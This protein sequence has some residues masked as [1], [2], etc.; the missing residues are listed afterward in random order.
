MKGSSSSSSSSSNGETN[1][2]SAKVACQN[3]SSSMLTPSSTNSS[4]LSSSTSPS[5]LHSSPSTCSAN[6]L[7]STSS[8]IAQ[9]NKLNSIEK[10][11]KTNHTLAKPSHSPHSYSNTTLT[12]SASP[13][14]YESLPSS[15]GIQGS[16]PASNSTTTPSNGAYLYSQY[17][18]GSN[19]FYPSETSASFVPQ[20]LSPSN[21][22]Y[23]TSSLTKPETSFANPSILNPID[24]NINYNNSYS[25]NNNSNILG[26][27][28]T[29]NNNNASST[30][31]NSANLN[32]L[33]PTGSHTKD[34]F[35]YNNSAYSQNYNLN[36]NNNSEKMNVDNATNYG[37][38]T[39]GSIGQEFTQ[40]HL[41]HTYSNQRMDVSASTFA[42]SV[43]EPSALISN[44]SSAYSHPSPYPYKLDSNSQELSTTHQIN[45]NLNRHSP[46]SSCSSTY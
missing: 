34:S 10:V 27:I 18:N 44:A 42:C 19:S 1:M 22:A 39:S 12:S 9:P 36:Y 20:S 28:S 24:F 32:A 17:S 15:T 35:Y 6:S 31:V 2:S 41:N 33:Q 4:P 46:Y 30:S 21:P 14:L 38:P 26:N 8:L 7:C 37:Y 25:S 16:A 11:A 5:S 29:V 23:Q 3:S 40:N 43:N 13:N 45:D